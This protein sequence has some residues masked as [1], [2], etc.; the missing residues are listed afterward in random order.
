MNNKLLLQMV[1]DGWN[2]YEIRKLY[3]ESKEFERQLVEKR[4]KLNK[5]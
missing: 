1:K 2:L 5:K 4:N 3:Q